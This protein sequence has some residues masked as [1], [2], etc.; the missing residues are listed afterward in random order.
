MSLAIL[1]PAAGA[2]QRMGGRDKLM[3][4]VGGEALLVRQVRRALATGAEVYVTLRKDRP[5]RADAL[6][7]APRAR[8]VWV[9]KPNE[10]IAAS[11]RAGIAALG[12]DVTA[13]MVLL[14]DL[15]EIEHS[16]LEAVIAA[17]RDHPGAVL[18]G[19]TVVGA[20]GHPVIFPRAWF[21]ALGRLKGD[22]GAGALLTGNDIRLHPLPGARALTDLDT[23]EAWEAWRKRTSL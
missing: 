13:V 5:K 22:Q 2:S 1:M 14:P 11:I 17:Y 9:E 23:P 4:L 6:N 16:D 12:V 18:R 7:K 10:G 19:A 8:H 3:E 21:D 20:P 15:P